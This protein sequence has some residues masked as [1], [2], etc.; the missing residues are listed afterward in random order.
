MISS[1]RERVRSYIFSSTLTRS[2]DL[3]CLTEPGDLS[4]FDRITKEVR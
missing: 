3:P 2:R 4:E 1:E